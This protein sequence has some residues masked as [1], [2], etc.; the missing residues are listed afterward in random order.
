MSKQRVVF[1]CQSCDG[2]ARSGRAGARRAGRGTRWSRSSQR[3]AGP[4]PVVRTG[5]RARC[6]SPRSTPRPRWRGPPASA[7]STGCSAGAWCRV[8]HAARGR[9]RHRQVHPA[10]AGRLAVA[11]AGGARCS[12][13]SAEESP[14]QVRVR[15]ERLGALRPKLWLAGRDDACPACSAPS[16]RWHPTWWWSTPSRRC[17]TPT[18]ASAPGSVAQVREC[19]AQAFVELAKQRDVAMVLVGHVT[20]DGS[21]AGPARARAPGRHRA[22]V[23]GRPPPRAAAAAGHQAPLRR[24]R[25]ARRCSRW[26]RAA[27]S[28]VDDAGGLFL[29]DRRPGVSGSAVVPVHRGPASAAGRAAGPGRARRQPHRQPAPLGAGRRPRPAS[30]CCWPCCSARGHRGRPG[31]RVRRRPSAG[32]GWSSPGPTSGWPWPWPRR[33]RASRSR[34]T[35]WRSAR[36]ASGAS[37]ARWRQRRAPAGRG[38]PAGVPPSHR[39]PPGARG[40]GGHRPA[41]G[42]TRLGEAVAAATGRVDTSLA[43]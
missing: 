34:P 13:S 18:L 25:R 12:T 24:H 14:Q 32:C 33:C 29:A 9:A 26:A 39:A 2:Q 17:T 3:A 35:W 10:A 31:R 23:R 19:C 7:S 36:S 38:R 11:T 43:R 1:R 37:C 40:P 41:S 6:P 8:G 4:A 27:S 30:T 28:V 5:E 22:V 21:L 16:T 15:A 20:K 42:S